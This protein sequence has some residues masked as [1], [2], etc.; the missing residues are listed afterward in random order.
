MSKPDCYEYVRNYYGV[1]AF[2]GG[3]VKIGQ[4]EGVL[5]RAR[6]DLHYIHVRLDGQ[7]HSV[8]AHPTS[9]VEYLSAAETQR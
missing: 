5:V 1:P 4:R 3:R 9:E 6:S 8:P 7:K 2:V